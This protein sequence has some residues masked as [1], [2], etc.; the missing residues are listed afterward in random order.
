MREIKFRAWDE[1]TKEMY[2]DATYIQPEEGEVRPW[3]FMQYT[4]LKDKNSKE[5]FEGDIVRSES[6]IVNIRTGNKTGEKS[7]EVYVMIWEKEKAMFNTQK[8][9][10]KNTNFNLRQEQMSKFYEVI[11]NIYEHPELLKEKT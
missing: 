11:G 9:S 3:I 7:I 2:Q 4:G 10:G 5:I 1:Y 8:L 6:D